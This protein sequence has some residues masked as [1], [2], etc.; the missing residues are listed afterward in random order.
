MSFKDK[1]V[2][3]T[4]GGSGIGAATAELFA[5]EKACVVIVGRNPD[6]LKKVAERCERLCAPTLIVKADLTKDEDL[7]EIV[8]ETIDRFG[9]IDVLVNNAGM[10]NF[11][12]ILD[13]HLME[14]F[15]TAI[16]TNLRA[17][18]Y[19]S[20]LVAPY[21]IKT[22]G[23]IVNVSSTYGT[24]L[25]GNP[26]FLSY[27]V[28][29]AALDHFGRGAALGLLSSGVRVNTVSPGP[30]RT[31]IIETA[32]L[33]VSWE[34]TSKAMKINRVSEPHEIGDLI[35]FLASDKAKSIT[36]ANYVID[37]GSLVAN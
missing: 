12:S 15:D 35:V 27:C 8:T 29:K 4:G 16:Q 36:G 37:N 23:N 17:P 2:I 30:T 33:Q 31:E 18:V 20:H 10:A 1:V 5:K 34:E 32:G 3:V 25:L 28:S 7:R 6:K 26:N 19:L 11:G 14:G 22:K 9:Q 24:S 13:E 21:L